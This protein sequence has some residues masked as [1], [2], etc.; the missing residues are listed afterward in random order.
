MWWIPSSFTDVQQYSRCAFSRQAAAASSV[1]RRFL[2]CAI[3]VTTFTRPRAPSST[4]FEEPNDFYGAALHVADAGNAAVAALRVP[5]GIYNVCRDG[6]R[7]SNARF[8]QASGWQ[9][10]H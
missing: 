9:P 2:S 1:G 10:L 6:E 7:V 8:K 4:R 5:S 3:G